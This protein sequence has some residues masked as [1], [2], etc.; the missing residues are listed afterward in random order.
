[1]GYRA[2]LEPIGFRIDLIQPLGG[3][4]RQFFNSRI[5]N[6]ERN[7]GPLA[8]LPLFIF[9]V[10]LLAFD[11]NRQEHACPYCYYVRARSD[12]DSMRI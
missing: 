5:K 12:N 11:S 7:F 1:M 9:A 6:V 4:I 3:P 2:F 10:P 8:A